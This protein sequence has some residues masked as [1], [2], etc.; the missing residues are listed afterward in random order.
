MTVKILTFTQPESFSVEEVGGESCRSNKNSCSRTPI[1]CLCKTPRTDCVCEPSRARIQESSSYHLTTLAPSYSR[2]SRAIQALQRAPVSRY[3]EGD[4]L[5]QKWMNCWKTTC[6][7]E[8]VW[9]N[10]T[11][12]SRTIR[13][14]KGTSRSLQT[15][16]R[17][18]EI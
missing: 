11:R 16:R 9:T 15:S 4:G 1:N 2:I 8:G 18:K 3:L 13:R 14:R 12:E 6:A 10:R 17:K 5:L 7:K